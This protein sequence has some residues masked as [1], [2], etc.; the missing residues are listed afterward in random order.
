V[1]VG[2]LENRIGCLKGGVKNMKMHVFFS[3]ID[4]DN[5]YHKKDTFMI[6]PKVLVNSH[7]LI[8]FHVNTTTQLVIHD[9]IKVMSF[10]QNSFC[11]HEVNILLM[12]HHI[13]ILNK[14][15]LL[16]FYH[17]A[18]ESWLL[19]TL[20]DMFHQWQNFKCLTCEHLSLKDGWTCLF[21]LFVMLKSPKP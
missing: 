13:I 20:C 11:K 3:S 10:S 17:M 15:R 4:W 19:C 9:N 14:T 18:M 16:S 21:V 7:Y 8:P 12:L 1:F 6:H 2:G 5:V